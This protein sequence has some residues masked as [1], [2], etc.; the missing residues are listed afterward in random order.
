MLVLAA[1]GASGFLTA[2][3]STSY[4]EYQRHS[5]AGVP[6]NHYAVIIDGSHFYRPTGGPAEMR[7]KYPRTT[8]QYL[9]WK[10]YEDPIKTGASV[11]AVLG[12]LTAA[13]VICLVYRQ[14]HPRRDNPNKSTPSW[15][16]R[17]GEACG[18]I[19]TT[20]FPRP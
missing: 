11:A 13:L 12:L 10:Q 20:V 14:S 6:L 9:Q 4:L 15:Q 7:P 1:L 17:A 18:R 5:R 2:V 3:I 16:Y 19:W 8:E